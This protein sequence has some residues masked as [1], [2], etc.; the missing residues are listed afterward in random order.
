MKTPALSAAALAMTLGTAH[1]ADHTDPFLWL[2][3]VESEQALTW[4]KKQNASTNDILTH[5]PSYPTFYQDSLDVLNASDR[6]AYPSRRGDYY[7]NFW[8]DDTHIKG[9]YRR[10]TPD[11]YAKAKPE[12][13]TVIDV[14]ALAKAEGEDWVLKGVDCYAPAYQRCM[15]ALSRGG[16]DATVKRE[17]DLTT[18]QFIADGF[19]LSEAKS[20]IT[21]L[22]NDHLL[23]AT[24]FGEGTLTDSGY[25]R[26]VKKWQRGTS[27][28]DAPVVYE[29]N[30]R[31]V[32]VGMFTLRDA[33][34]RMTLV[35][36]GET[37]YRQQTF[38][39]DKN[40]LRPL[41][42][43]ADSEILGYF[44]G[45]LFFQLKSD[46]H[47]G[48][49][50]FRQGSILSAALTDLTT[51]QPRYQAF[52]VPDTK[53][54]IESVDFT[55]RHIIV[56]E[57]NDVS[58]R[59]RVLHKDAKGDW[60]QKPVELEKNT[61][62]RVFNT[63]PEHDDFFVDVASFLTPPSIYRVD[64]QSHETRRLKST[65]PKFDA[66]DLVVEQHFATSKDGTQ[67]PYFLV[68]SKALKR[69]GKNPTLLYGYGGFE[70]SLT[71]HYSALLGKNWLEKGGVYVLANIRG[72]GE[73]GPAWHLA[74]LKHQ[75][76]KAYQDFE[77][78]AEDVIGKKITTPAHLGIQGGSNGGLLVGAAVTRRP[79][80]YQAVVCQVP[81]LDMKRF[82]KLLAGAS[83]M[84]E[85]GN[86]DTEADWAYLKTYSPYHNLSQD[87]AYPRVLFTTSTRDDRVHPAHARKM[88]AKMQ[89][90]GHDV[91]YYE[92]MEGGHAGASNN[93]TRAA[94]YAR[95]YTYLASQLALRTDN[96]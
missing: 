17:F 12:W 84:A 3:E 4:V 38:W 79:E 24:D 47:Q 52:L 1:G 54:S 53:T 45:A 58:S 28:K 26:L 31:S 82:N 32:S 61:H 19:S 29:G 60:Q 14:D 83:W 65:P 42:L 35:R 71:P 80:L 30:P 15:V 48:D 2:E 63:S 91:L 39:L 70:V 23:V 67:V 88:V 46:L 11:S 43:P 49:T 41:T 20:D 13:E 27:L 22:D 96:D 6:L 16:A 33:H 40:T 87:T 94:M 93:A 37:F 77:A 85:Y 56:S 78:V 57:L 86:P 25:P 5:H 34:S 51:E 7:Y 50:H 92:N 36:E 8:Q 21:W 18:K 59:I 75:R 89:A 76:H 68:A 64:A 10:T 44:E 9:I 66:N 62:M 74:A 55:A 95:T 90:M 73:Y 69:D 72:G 81:L